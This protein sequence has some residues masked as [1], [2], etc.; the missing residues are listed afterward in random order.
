MFI[1]ICTYHY[2]EHKNY[3]RSEG[4]V[5]LNTDSI[6]LAEQ[7]TDAKYNGKTGDLYIMRLKDDVL[8][9]ININDITDHF[10]IYE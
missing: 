2:K 5:I 10:A 4:S 1:Q 7:I 8:I 9:T 3:V 6:I